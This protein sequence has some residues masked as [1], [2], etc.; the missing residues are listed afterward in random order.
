LSASADK[1]DAVSNTDAA[2]D[3]TV[4]AI[5]QAIEDADGAQVKAISSKDLS[6]LAAGATNEFAAQQKAVSQGLIEEGVTEIKLMHIEWGPI[7]VNGTNA[8]VTAFETWIATYS[9]GLTQQSRERNAY[10][11]VQQD[12]AWKVQSYEHPDQLSGGLPDP[13]PGGYWMPH[14]STPLIAAQYL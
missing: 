13:L 11:I 10:T 4:A 7:N 6:G 1:A 2:S 5:K 9:D 12:G 14:L 8:T 3:T